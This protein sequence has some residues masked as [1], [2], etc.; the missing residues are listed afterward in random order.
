LEN[1]RVCWLCALIIIWINECWCACY[2]YRH[3]TRCI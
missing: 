3:F 1:I 2:C